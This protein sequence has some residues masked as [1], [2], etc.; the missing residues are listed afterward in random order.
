MDRS[1]APV[2][3]VIDT[4]DP[5]AL[6]TFWA[7]A[8]APRGYAIPDPPGDFADW[9]AFL[10]AQ[11]VPEERWNDASAL[12]APGQPRLFFQRVPEPKTVKNRV[13]LDLLAGGGPSV[14]LDLQRERVAAEVARLEE[15]GASRVDEHSDLGVHWVTMRD[16]EGNEFCV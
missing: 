6:V 14:P 15:L 12:E 10:A 16:P 1:I 3:V 9:P 7:A 13:H 2:Q 5:A 11:G 4:A 8:L